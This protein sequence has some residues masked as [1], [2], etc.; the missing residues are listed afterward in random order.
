MAKRKKSKQHP[1]SRKVTDEGTEQ[2]ATAT[3]EVADVAKVA[4][5]AE[6]APEQEQEATVTQEVVDSAQAAAEPELAA[7]PIS[8]PIAM[9]KRKKGKQNAKS[10]KVADPESEPESVA[11]ATAEA[12][13]AAELPDAPAEATAEA[14]PED[15]STEP[16]TEP[17]AADQAVD[18]SDAEAELATPAEGATDTAAEAATDAESGDAPAEAATD[19]EQAQP[20]SE[21][22]SAQTT[23]GEASVS[24]LGEAEAAASEPPAETDGQPVLEGARLESIIESLL[25]ASDKALS[26]SD[27]RRLLGERDGKKITAAVEALIERRWDSGIQVV[28]QSNGWHLRTAVDN[29]AW[30]SKLLVGKPVRLSRDMMETLAIVAYRQPV[31]RPEVDDIRGVD[32]G[33]VLKTLLERGL[34]RIIGK[35]EEV[36]RPMLYGTTPEFLRV[37]NLR[38]L[39]ELPTLREFYDLSAEDQS[40][41]DSEHGDAPQTPSATTAKPDV[42]LNAVARGALAPEPEDSDP[43]LDEL[44]EASL[45]AKQAL[46]G[47]EPSSEEKVEETQGEAKAEPEQP[48]PADE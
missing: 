18:A 47:L 38:D 17:S 20:D 39:T 48:P 27:L 25:F 11:D 24:P 33:A 8:K 16:E 36:G 6:S 44:D 19:A 7:E 37:F 14:T 30:V 10:K 3:Q 21:S 31:T 45:A 9:P 40:K 34:V 43:L 12:S 42:A 15:S 2:S 13:D 28:A 1:K 23:E 4:T 46:G 5:E 32:C 26:L 29:A 22:E 41:V 35:K